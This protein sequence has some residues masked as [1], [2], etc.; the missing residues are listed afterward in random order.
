VSVR[1]NS[2]NQQCKRDLQLT[3]G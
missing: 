1:K 2:K 3:M